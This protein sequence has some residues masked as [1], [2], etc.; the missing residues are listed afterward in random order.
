MAAVDYQDFVNLML[1][2]RGGF[3][4]DIE[5]DV[6]DHLVLLAD[7]LSAAHEGTS[8]AADSGTAADA[9]AAEESKTD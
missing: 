6:N 7:N 4:E 9:E 5:A 1:D 8:A 2:F 3:E